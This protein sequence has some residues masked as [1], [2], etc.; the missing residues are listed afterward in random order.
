MTDNLNSNLRGR[1]EKEMLYMV[2]EILTV[3]EVAE[4]LQI[5][6]SELRKLMLKREINYFEIGESDSKRK[7][8]RFRL[9]DVDD[10]INQNYFKVINR[11]EN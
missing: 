2:K 3:K 5:S 11:L 4:L 8:K 10:Y 7:A 9:S 6:V 1:N